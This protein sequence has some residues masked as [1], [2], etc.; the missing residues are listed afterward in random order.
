MSSLGY[1]FGIVVNKIENKF[2]E[3]CS[4]T[5]STRRKS[6]QLQSGKV[7]TRYRQNITHGSKAKINF[8][9]KFAKEKA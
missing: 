8:I 3:S 2:H 1:P 9:H 6:C 5:K 4:F 7:N